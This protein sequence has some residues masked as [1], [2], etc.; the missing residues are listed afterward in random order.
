MPGKVTL[1]LLLSCYQVFAH[2]GIEPPQEL[3]VNVYPPGKVVL[4][5]KHTVPPQNETVLYWVIVN[6]SNK[7]EEFVTYANTFTHITELHNGLSVKVAALISDKLTDWVSKDIPPYPGADGTSATDLSCQIDIEESEKYC[8]SCTWLPGVKAPADTDYYLYY[9]SDDVTKKCEDY[10]TEPGGQRRTGCCILST[11]ISI[12]HSS[13]ILVHINGTSKSLQIK[14]VEQTFMSGHIETIP[15]VR[16]LTMDVNG[17]H[18]RKPLN[19]IPDSC[20]NY[21]VNIWSKG[22]NETITIGHSSYSSDA[23]K[24]SSNKKFI[25]VRAIGKKPCWQ[26]KLSAWKNIVTEEGVDRNDTL[27]IIIPACLIAA[28]IVIF[29][30]C[31]RFWGHIFPQIPKPKNELKESFPNVRSQAL[32]R[33][34]SLDNEEVI[35]YIEELVESDNTSSNYG[36]IGNYSSSGLCKTL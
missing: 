17:L 19:T 18:W 34:N 35:S 9:R 27:G 7:S 1:L 6:T 13:L 30:L 5:W 10:V 21:E 28:C 2:D 24:K 14:A 36:H 31:I 26:H 8:L 20:F 16:N 32:M 11:V 25:C 4:T 22:S 33:C 29:L 23:L 15:P 3:N 12:K